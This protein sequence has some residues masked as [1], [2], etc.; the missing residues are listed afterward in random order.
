MIV[1]MIIFMIIVNNITMQTEK[2]SAN[3]SCEIPLD[4]I[5]GHIL[6]RVDLE[7]TFPLC[8]IGNFESESQSFQ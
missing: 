2:S 1:A 8:L 4:E 6:L 3:D 7:Y 5:V